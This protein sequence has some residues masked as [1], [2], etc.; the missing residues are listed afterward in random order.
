MFTYCHVDILQSQTFDGGETN[1]HNDRLGNKIEVAR[2][3]INYGFI[4]PFNVIVH[5]FITFHPLLNIL[6]SIPI[7]ELKDKTPSDSLAHTNDTFIKMISLLD[8]CARTPQHFQRLKPSTN[9]MTTGDSQTRFLQQLCEKSFPDFIG[10][11]M[12]VEKL[13]YLLNDHCFLA[14]SLFPQTRLYVRPLKY[15]LCNSILMFKTILSSTS[16]FDTNLSC[17]WK[18][19]QFATILES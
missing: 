10:N 7:D 4:S 17:S 12:S 1:C 13:V 18:H 8:L 19:L 15:R 5:F 16:N 9:L 3:R 2:G 14:N 6:S 11:V